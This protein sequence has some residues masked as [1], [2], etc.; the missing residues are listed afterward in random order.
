MK[1]CKNWT[2]FFFN[3]FLVPCIDIFLLAVHN[4]K[5]IYKKYTGGI[6]T[7]KRSRYTRQ[8]NHWQRQRLENNKKCKEP[9][10]YI[11]KQKVFIFRHYFLRN[12]NVYGDL[13]FVDHW[14]SDNTLRGNVF[15]VTLCVCVLTCTCVY[16]LCGSSVRKQEYKLLCVMLINDSC[17]YVEELLVLDSLTGQAILS[18]PQLQNRANSSNKS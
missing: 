6:K 13:L 8:P 1:C 14:L 4:F 9:C 12:K 16:V 7:H 2:I 15:P 10:L 3:H 5:C 17:D 18:I 11:S